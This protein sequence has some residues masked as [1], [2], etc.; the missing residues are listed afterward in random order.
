M[1]A[2]LLLEQFERLCESPGAIVGLRSFVY[3]LAVR[4]RLSAT[5]YHGEP[6]SEFLAR[7]RESAPRFVG[8]RKHA[9]QPAVTQMD[10]PFSIPAGWEWIRF[11]EIHQLTRGVSYSKS[12]VS[13]GPA[14]GYVPVLR[15]S[16]IGS[17]LTFDDP[18]FVKAERASSEQMLLQ[19]DF[20]IAMS[21]GS[22]DLVGKFAFVDADTQYAFGGFCG[23]LR[24]ASPELIPW[25][26]VFL[27]SRLYRDAVL[28]DGGG[29]GINNLKVGTLADAWFPC[30]P[31]AEQIRIIAKV[32]ELMVLCDKFDDAKA[33][34]VLSQRSFSS[35][36]ISRLVP[37]KGDG[38]N[39]TSEDLRSGASVALDH[40]PQL[41]A[42][43][44][45]VQRLR[46]SV[47]D[48]A[49][50]GRLVLQNSDDEPAVRLVE[51]IV[52]R[53]GKFN[54]PSG[55]RSQKPLPA[56]HDTDRSF[57]IPDSWVWVRLGVLADKISDGEHLSPNKSSVGMPLL[58]AK[59]VS[60][61]GLTLKDPQY[62]SYED[63][64]RFRQRCDPRRGD[65][66]ICSRGT[67]GRCVVVDTDEVFC[68]MGSVIQIRLPRECL[69]EYV[70]YFLSTDMA[71]RQMRGMSGSTAVAALY[72]KDIRLCPVP[73]PPLAEQHRIVAKVN[74]L[75]TLCDRLSGHLDARALD[76]GRLFEVALREA[77]QSDREI[78]LGGAKV[79]EGDQLK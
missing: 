68:L 37:P 1:T 43:V 46:G 45:D 33:R 35:S 5:E 22:R 69:P 15:A 56:I 13:L 64:L 75:V 60:A 67:I 30:P 28:G 14:S 63:G 19:G 7:I 71:Q 79:A 20:M 54:S 24:V 42:T 62:V 32:D 2:A 3:D 23:V 10:P 34:R 77:L 8:K 55:A 39:K 70:L 65:L 51:Q 49:V 17:R 53:R 47:L 74:E 48:L 27:S 16:N 6:A 26:R 40:L 58:T 38:D 66:L 76:T 50:R 78:G 73:L 41:T 4:G 57:E 12:D 59:H 29:V 52:I 44:Q 18:V 31:P 72:L 36:S 21:S 11:G 9:P 25:T 61:S